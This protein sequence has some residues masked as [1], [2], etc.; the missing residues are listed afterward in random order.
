MRNNEDILFDAEVQKLFTSFSNCFGVRV[1]FFNTNVEAILYGEPSAVH[2]F[3]AMIRNDMHLLMRCLTQDKTM[4]KYCETHNKPFTYRCFAGPTESVMPIKSG[5]TLIGYGMV[6][7]F[8]TIKEVPTEFQEKYRDDGGELKKLKNL[9]T[10]I[11]YIEQKNSENMLNLFSMM[12]NYIM[13]QQYIGL[14]RLTVSEQI[15]RLINKHQTEA[16]TI[17]DIAI[18]V[19]KSASSVSH[20]IKEQFGTSFKQLLIKKRIQRFEYIINTE[21][22]L[23]IAE[24][25]ARVG[26][27]DAF[28][29]SRL[30]KKVRSIT[31]REYIRKV[32]AK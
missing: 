29:F 19:N 13:T 27:D 3:C 24:A 17:N 28:Y 12:V 23:N 1:T 11:P 7:Q 21:P 14:R 20:I 16:L 32:H 9:F 10:D 18:A 31:P 15:T 6:G 22:S 4:C 30:Y 2:P 26:Y 8:R 5:G 25:A